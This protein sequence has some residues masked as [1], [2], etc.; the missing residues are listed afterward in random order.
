MI[1]TLETASRGPLTLRMRSGLPGMLSETMTRAPDFSLISLTCEPALP[2]MM[3]ASCVTMRQRM[4]MWAEGGG[5][6]GGP[7]EDDGWPE[8]AA[9][10]IASAG[11]EEA[12]S[13]LSSSRL[14]R[15]LLGTW[16]V[17]AAVSST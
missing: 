10:A 13:S 3:D 9:L 1:K 12:A 6:G 16:G 5:G 2:M 15:S 17:D 8:L 4:W 7:D 11:E 14:G